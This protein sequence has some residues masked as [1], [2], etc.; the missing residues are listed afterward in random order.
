MLEKRLIFKNYVPHLRLQ[1]FMVNIHQLYLSQNRFESHTQRILGKTIAVELSV[2]MMS[3]TICDGI[4]Y[5][6]NAAQRE[7]ETGHDT[8]KILFVPLPSQVSNNAH[9][10]VAVAASAMPSLRSFAIS[11]YV[12]LMYVDTSNNLHVDVLMIGS[13]FFLFFAP[14]APFVRVA[15]I[16]LLAMIYA[17]SPNTHIHSPANE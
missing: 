7:W 4:R 17:R 14:F 2:C 12:E 10:V 6:L 13:I 9:C 16:C 8:N 1:K 3:I 5:Q 11:L 15:A